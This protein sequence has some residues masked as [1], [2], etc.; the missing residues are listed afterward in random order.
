MPALSSAGSQ[1]VSMNTRCP[2]TIY[3]SNKRQRSSIG[4]GFDG[5]RRAVFQALRKGATRASPSAG[6]PHHVGSDYDDGFA[7][8]A[9]DAA[10][11]DRQIFGAGG[12]DVGA[13]SQNGFRLCERIDEHAR[14]GRWAGS[15]RRWRMAVT[16]PKF[17]PPPR[18]AQNKSSSPTAMFGGNDAPIRQDNFSGK[19]IIERKPKSADQRL[20]NRRPV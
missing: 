17:P 7:V 9:A 18:N 16:T 1:H 2:L 6:R 12:G 5:C 15:C 20:H 8:G 19:Q 13:A 10:K 14:R 3:G 11:L 4:H